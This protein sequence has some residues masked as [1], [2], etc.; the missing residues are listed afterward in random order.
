MKARTRRV[1]SIVVSYGTNILVTVLTALVCLRFLQQL[2]FTMP[3]SVAGVL[4]LLFCTTHLHYTQNMME[5][6]Y[7]MLLT[8]TGFSFQ[9]EWLR[10]GSRR[11]LLIG[12]A[13]FGL[14]L[15]T[16][17]TTVSICWLA[18]C[19]CCWC[20]G[21]NMQALNEF[22]RRLFTY[23][24]TAAPVYLVFVLIDRIYQHYRF[25]SYMNTYVTVFAQEAKRLNP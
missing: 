20:C 9:Y 19:S 16:R 15:L 6:N 13:A 7:I 24:K 5:N 12:S 17:L 8:L 3:Q 4:A 23:V 11:A 25:G 2:G 1:R 14:N 18:A 10:T 21:L 22:W